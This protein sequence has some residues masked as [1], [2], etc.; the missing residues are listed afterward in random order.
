MSIELRIVSICLVKKEKKSFILCISSSST[1]R[2]L[3]IKGRFR[4]MTGMWNEHP[5]V[6]DS[7][8]SIVKALPAQHSL[9][10]NTFK[11]TLLLDNVAASNHLILNS[12]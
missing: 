11:P 4:V 9:F 12:I 8:R 7:L 2:H 10:L 1:G 3:G 5:L 6:S